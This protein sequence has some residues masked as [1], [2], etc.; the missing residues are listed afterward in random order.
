MSVKGTDNFWEVRGFID[1]FKESHMKIAS[2]V[3]RM[4]YKSM[5]AIQFCNTPKGDLLYYSY[6]FR[7][8]DPLGTETNIMAWYRLGNMLHLEI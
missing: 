1:G 5:G 6:I 8:L 4:E 7:K 2:G 3:K